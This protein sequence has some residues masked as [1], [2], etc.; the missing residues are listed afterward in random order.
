MENKNFFEVLD[1][2]SEVIIYEGQ[3]EK[4]FQEFVVLNLAITKAKND[5]LTGKLDS[6]AFLDFLDQ[7]GFDVYAL[8]PRDAQC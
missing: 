7:S 4:E 2:E 5:F 3:S 8:F 6:D 1:Q